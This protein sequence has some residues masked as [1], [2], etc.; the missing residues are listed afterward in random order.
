MSTILTYLD[1]VDGLLGSLLTRE[2]IMRSKKL[3]IHR[4]FKVRVDRTMP[5]EF[6]GNLTPPFCGLWGAEVGFDYSDYD[7]A[8]SHLGGDLQAD[9]QIIWLDWRIYHKSI[10]PQEAANWLMGR[11]EQLREGMDTTIWVNNWPE[12]Q[13]EENI[14]FSLRASDRG[15]TRRLNVCL[16]DLIENTTGCELIDLAG[17]AHERTGFFF[18][19]RNEQISNYPFSDQATLKIARHLGVHLFPAVFMPR[20]KAIALDLDDTLYSGVLGEEGSYGVKLSEGHCALQKLLL[21]LKH[22]GILLTICSRNEEEDVKALFESRADFPI[23]WADFAAICA[24]WQ[25]KAENI[26]H[27]AQQLNI[28]PSAFLFID[29]NSAE[30]LKMASAQPNVQLL[31][32]DQNG[33]ETMSK[34]S[35]YPGLYQ[36]HP[37]GEASSRTYDIQANQKREKL[38]ISAS[39]FNS[40]LDS[41]GMVISIY[42][43]EPSHAGRLYGLSHKTNQFNL[44]LRRMTEIEIKEIMITAK[45]N[46]LTITISL[47]DLLSESGII[48]AFVCHIEGRN[49]RLIETLV[50]C[51]ALGREVETVSFAYLLEKLISLEVD[52]LSIDVTEGPRNNPAFDWLKRFV[53]GNLDNLCLTKLL[54]DVK[55]ACLNHPARVEVIK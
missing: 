44:A 31:R 11:I 22:S 15:W 16:A 3:P 32:A 55:G 13:D 25:P 39:S 12:P 50:S 52:N 49:A 36:L 47:S 9:I 48:G 45:A 28:D 1:S 42:E 4:T 34:I 6:I 38:K 46:Y 20:L 30:L 54:L 2:R 27:L 37:D 43:N 14:I 5:F 23:K 10:T 41:L 24:N 29:D 8:L 33:R 26:N 40:Y 53:P 18:D 21:R 51:R 7:V 35:Y 19:D 17:L